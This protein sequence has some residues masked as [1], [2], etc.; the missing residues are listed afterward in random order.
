MGSNSLFILALVNISISRFFLPAFPQ[1]ESLRQMWGFN[2]EMGQREGNSNLKTKKASG[3][4]QIVWGL[5]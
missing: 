3:K 1:L 5:E 2:S 4:K